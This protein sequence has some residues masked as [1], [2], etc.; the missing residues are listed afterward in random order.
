MHLFVILGNN[1]FPI[2]VE[3]LNFI[4][5]CLILTDTICEISF[6]CTLCIERFRAIYSTT[7]Q[8]LGAIDYHIFCLPLTN[9]L[10]KNVWSRGVCFRVVTGSTVIWSPYICFVMFYFDGSI[11]YIP[12]LCSRFGCDFF[13]CG[14]L[15]SSSRRHIFY[16]YS[17]DPL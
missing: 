15:S 10:K 11:Q 1:P 3:L 17:G 5:F 2:N 14:Y 6:K 16:I 7:W 13:Y 9:H 12:K 4:Y 8:Y